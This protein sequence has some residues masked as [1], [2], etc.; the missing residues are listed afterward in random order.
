MCRSTRSI[1]H[2]GLNQ[3]GRERQRRRLLEFPFIVCE[4]WKLEIWSRTKI[5]MI[6]T[7]LFT[8]PRNPQNRAFHVLFPKAGNT[9]GEF[10][11]QSQRIWRFFFLRLSLFFVPKAF[12]EGNHAIKT[13]NWLVE[14]A[15]DSLRQMV[16]KIAG[17]G[18]PDG[19][20][21]NLCEL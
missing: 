4:N 20:A 19:P 9:G 16:H 15:S 12:A 13:Q 3:L 17:K 1:R 11:R 18:T 8:F 14:W 2:G 10:I 6:S 21:V 5:K 7:L